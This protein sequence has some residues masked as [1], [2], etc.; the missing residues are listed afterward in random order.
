MEGDDLLHPLF[1]RGW[2]VGVDVHSFGHFRVRLTGHHPPAAGENNLVRDTI[3]G[4]QEAGWE[5]RRAAHPH[6]NTGWAR[7][8]FEH[9]PDGSQD[10]QLKTLPSCAECWVVTFDCVCCYN[11][12][13]DSRNSTQKSLY[14]K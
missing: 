12:M 7:R 6:C 9:E 8:V 11:F 10:K 13:R 14:E 3:T 4:Q 1:P 5:A 2:T